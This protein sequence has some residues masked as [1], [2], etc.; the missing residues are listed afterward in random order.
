VTERE[1][2]RAIR[3]GE[4][5]ALFRSVN[6]QVRGISDAWAV[7]D[8][9]IRV[10]CECGKASCVEQIQ[11]HSAEYEQVRGDGAL[12]VVRPGHEDGDVEDVVVRTERYWTVRKHPGLPEAIAEATD[13]R[14][15]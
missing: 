12:F 5:E 7:R 10:V 4:N 11:L 14:D 8:D 1:R 2:L 13:P 3:I 9:T 15:P 6:E